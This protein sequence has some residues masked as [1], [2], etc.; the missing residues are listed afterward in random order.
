MFRQFKYETRQALVSM[1][2]ILSF[3]FSILAITI[4]IY[5]YGFEHA[6]SVKSNLF[7]FIKLIFVF[8]IFN[9][10]VRL[11][12]SR[13]RK[14]FLEN[15]WFEGL[16]MI[17][18]ISD[19]L[20]LILYGY[21]SLERLFSGIGIRYFTPFYIFFVQIYL[22]LFVGIHTIKA[23]NKLY[24]FNIKPPVIFVLSFLTLILGGAGL[25]MLPEMTVNEG[26]TTFINAL[27]TSVSATTVT[28]LIVVD[29]ATYFT[30]KGHLIILILMQ[31]GGIGIITFAL[32]FGILT[33]HG[34]G[35]MQQSALKEYFN[36]PNLFA[37]KKILGQ[38]IGVT[39]T[40]EIIGIMFMHSLWEPHHQ[41][42]SY[43]EKL[44][45][46]IFHSV[47]AFCNAG[48]SLFS[49]GFASKNI[50]KAYIL[51]IITGILIFLGSLGFPAIRD[52]T[53]FKNLRDR[54]KN[55]WKDWHLN[56][57]ISLVS[58]LIL[59]IIGSALFILLEKDNIF[60]NSN[61]FETIVTSMFQV[62]SSRTAGFNTIDIGSLTEPTL[63]IIII[64]MFIGGS[65]ISVAGG[66][67]TSTFVILFV[68]FYA[69]LRGNKRIVLDNR[70]VTSEQLNRAYAIFVFSTSFILISTFFISI[71]EPDK[72]MMQLVF[73]SVSAFCTV[74]YST[75]ITGDLSIPGKWV[76]LITMFVGRVGILTLVWTLVTPKKKDNIL[77]PKSNILIG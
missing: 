67:K 3:V 70:T 45:Y 71:V 30:F 33:R 20:H 75:G 22:L 18:L 62:V 13:D 27:F 48:F 6:E 14:S 50:E 52:L 21:P 23:V 51:H 49:D 8:F 40:I 5:Y 7:W 73:E 68:S 61:T 69:T 10:A 76:I 44:F 12:Y 64:L 34:L 63:I 16:L 25:L 56:T 29:T 19:V 74:G 65:S 59:L 43:G 72:D 47:S 57:K 39:I 2:K 60:K 38:V 42:D 26:T 54:M 77:Y 66:I 4:F 58:S 37:A 28:G 15:N 17:L 55:P 36:T 11:W 24:F 32:F 53:S 9:Y 1:L 41:F 46:S 35:I 31:L